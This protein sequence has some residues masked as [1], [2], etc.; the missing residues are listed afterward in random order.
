MVKGCVRELFAA[1]AASRFDD[2]NVVEKNRKNLRP[3]VDDES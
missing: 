2:L 3:G 1:S